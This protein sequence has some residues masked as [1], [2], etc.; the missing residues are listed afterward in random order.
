MRPAA[1]SAT[2]IGA[3]AGLMSDGHWRTLAE[4]ASAT[5][6]PES[7]ISARLRDLRKPP[8]R[9]IVQRRRRAVGSGTY[10]YRLVPA[11]EGAAR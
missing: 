8:L 2:R 1:E 5:G 9:R 4:I 3:V 7:G 10:E 6:Q 11:C